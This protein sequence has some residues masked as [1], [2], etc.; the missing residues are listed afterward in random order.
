[1]TVLSE[2]PGAWTTGGNFTWS[3]LEESDAER[4]ATAELS[5]HCHE[6]MGL[7]SIWREGYGELEDAFR[8]LLQLSGHGGKVKSGLGGEGSKRTAGPLEEDDVVVLDDLEVQSAA[9][10]EQLRRSERGAFLAPR[11]ERFREPQ[12]EA[13]PEFTSLAIQLGSPAP[14]KGSQELGVASSD[15]IVR[16][17]GSGPDSDCSSSGSFDLEDDEEWARRIQQVEAK[18]HRYCEEDDENPVLQGPRLYMDFL[19][20]RLLA[21]VQLG[22]GCQ[23]LIDRTWCQILE[24]IKEGDETSDALPDTHSD[25]EDSHDSS[26]E[27]L[28]RHG[29]GRRRPASFRCRPEPGQKD[30][31]PLTRLMDLELLETE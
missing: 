6:L 29:R 16:G 25:G 28:C 19:Q 17:G 2:Q 30:D 4:K 15:Y 10:G 11:C 18:R 5:R 3:G 12:Q 31:G 27:R 8:E 20:S 14:K 21:R 13:C 24:Q 9:G 23:A 7:L 1:M 26:L 22:D